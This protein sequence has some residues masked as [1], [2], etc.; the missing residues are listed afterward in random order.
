MSQLVDA[1]HDHGV[2]PLLWQALESTRGPG[3]QLRN[4]L[5]DGVRAAATADVF[6]QRDMQVVLAALAAAHVRAL[7]IK[8]SALAYTVYSKPWL[9]PRTDT[10]LLVPY[11]DVPAAMQALERCGYTRSDALTSGTFVS[12]QIAFERTDEHDV[13]HVVDLHWKVVNPQILADSLPFEDLWGQAEPAPA[14]GPAARVPAPVAS[15]LLGCIHRLA[16]HQGHD[17]LIW[18]YDLRLLTAGFD[19]TDWRAL[20]RLA[21]SSGVAGLCLDGLRQAQDHLGMPLPK[22]LPGALAAAARAEPSQQ[23]LQGTVRQRDVLL[24]DL[25]KLKGWRARLRLLRE[26]AF[27]PVAF[28]RQRYGVNNPLLTPALYVLRLV[29]GAYQWGRPW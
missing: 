7:V 24:S 14:L 17:R 1:A 23:Y 15:V 21:C 12:H 16:H 6:I 18:L 28:I 19:D 5:A 2:G 13:H 25:R 4:A 9:R 11:G 8:G 29:T 22:A 26:H 27:P 10:D 20:E 3:L